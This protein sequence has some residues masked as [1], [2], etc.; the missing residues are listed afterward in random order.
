MCKSTFCIWICSC[1]SL[2]LELVCF[3]S[4]H[5][6]FLLNAFHKNSRL[7]NYLNGLK[8]K[9]RYR[10]NSSGFFLYCVFGKKCSN[11]RSFLFLLPVAEFSVSSD[12]SRGGN[13]QTAQMPPHQFHGQHMRLLSRRSGFRFRILNT[14]LH[15]LRTHIDARHPSTIRSLFADQTP[16]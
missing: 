4:K 12:C 14:K 6:P 3:M 15:R 7:L 2:E 13:V 8:F 16:S 5:F 10:R 9:N 1:L 11:K